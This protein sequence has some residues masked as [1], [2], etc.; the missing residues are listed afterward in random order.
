MG[1]RL[2]VRDIIWRLCYDFSLY[3]LNLLWISFSIKTMSKELEKRAEKIDEAI[4]AIRTR[5]TW[6][7]G[8]LVAIIISLASFIFRDFDG[9]LEVGSLYWAAWHTAII[10]S[11]FYLSILVVY[12]YLLIAPDYN[13]LIDE[14]QGSMSLQE[15]TEQN[16]QILKELV[17]NFRRLIFLF[18]ISVPTSLTIGSGLWYFTA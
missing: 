16:A 7:L 17:T 13:D 3:K 14:P 6:M 8:I 2:H 11:L 10:S 1:K 9:G 4:K 15:Q 18:V 5:A 12:M